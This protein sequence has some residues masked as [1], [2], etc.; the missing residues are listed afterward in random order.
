MDVLFVLFVVHAIALVQS[1]T[2][3][4]LSAKDNGEVQVDTSDIGENEKWII[5]NKYDGYVSLKSACFEKYL[6]C[7]SVFTCSDSIMAD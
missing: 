7:D 4:Y 1:W 3:M 2:G 6:V 5:K